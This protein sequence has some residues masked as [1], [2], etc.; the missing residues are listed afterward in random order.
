MKPTSPRQAERVAALPR[1]LFFA[2]L[3]LYGCWASSDEVA[4]VRSPAGDVEGVVVEVNGGATTTFRYDIYL[5]PAGQK[6]YGSRAVAV[7][8]GA[9]RSEQAYG[10][11]LR[12]ISDQALS[13]EYF[14]AK[15]AKVAESSVQVGGRDIWVALQPGVS[16]PA[17]PIGGMLYNLNLERSRGAPPSRK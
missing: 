13:V 11:N 9:A 12:W 4:R 15:T 8:V 5:V 10:V 1:A 17:A 6:I 14:E 16:D 2:C 3:V 7:L